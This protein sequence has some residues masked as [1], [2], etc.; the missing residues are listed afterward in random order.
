M[1]VLNPTQYES[2]DIKKDDPD[3]TILYVVA[4]KELNLPG[5]KLAV[6]VGHLTELIAVEFYSLLNELSNDEWHKQ[7]IQKYLDYTSTG[8]RKVVLGA[9]DKEFEKIKTLHDCYVV[10]DAGLTVVAPNTETVLGFW[11]N[12]K[13]QAPKLI[14]RLQLLK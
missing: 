9:D 13:S 14:Q 11:P 5:A 3:P 12:K 8:T 10:R 2:L 7:E 4:R 6:Q 1:P